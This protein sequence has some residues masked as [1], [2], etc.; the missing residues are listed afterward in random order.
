[1][2]NNTRSS[3]KRR[4]PPRSASGNQPEPNAQRGLAGRERQTS[5]LQLGSCNCVSAAARETQHAFR[6]TGAALFGYH[7]RVG[8][9]S[10]E[11]RQ[12]LATATRTSSVFGHQAALS[13]PSREKCRESTRVVCSAKKVRHC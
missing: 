10:T 4:Q 5:V 12:W 11:V 7:A 13:K 9:R 8:A 3:T 2:G 6:S 1:M